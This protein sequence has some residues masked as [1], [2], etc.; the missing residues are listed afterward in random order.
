[1]QISYEEFI[2]HVPPH[3]LH[4][5]KVHA[6]PRGHKIVLQQY[7]NK[8]SLRGACTA[9]CA[10]CI[11]KIVET[12]NWINTRPEPPR[13]PYGF[14]TL[15]VKNSFAVRLEE[16]VKKPVAQPETNLLGERTERSVFDM[17]LESVE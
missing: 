9:E 14:F 15:A 2:L 4:Q 1:M 8:L 7:C 6:I 13:E 3:N 11:L 12:V 5:I 10:T 16:I 17:F